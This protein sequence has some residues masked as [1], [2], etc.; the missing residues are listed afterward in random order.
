MSKK[1]RRTMADVTTGIRE[2]SPP[3]AAAPA[4]APALEPEPAPET[5][6]SRENVATP[7]GFNVRKER[8]EKPHQSVYAHPVVFRELRK[9]AAAEDVKPQDL[10]REGLREVFRRRGLDFDALD[11]GEEV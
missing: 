10:Y 3:P 5:T 1:P 4:P 11:R 7:R 9:I 2:M 6:R 8:I